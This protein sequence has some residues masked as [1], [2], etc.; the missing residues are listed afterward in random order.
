MNLIYDTPVGEILRPLIIIKL[1]LY[2]P[3]NQYCFST[4]EGCNLLCKQIKHYR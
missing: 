1:L 3:I 4:V 2:F